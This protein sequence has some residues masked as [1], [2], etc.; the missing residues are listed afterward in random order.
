MNYCRAQYAF[1]CIYYPG[2][3]EGRE[4]FRSRAKRRGCGYRCLRRVAV[5]IYERIIRMGDA[6]DTVGRQW[7]GRRWDT[8][9][10]N[11]R[12]MFNADLNE[13]IAMFIRDGRYYRQGANYFRTS[14]RRRR[15]SNECRRVRAWWDKRYRSVGFA[16]FSYY[17]FRLRPFND[18]GRCS[19][20]TSIRCYFS[21]NLRQHVLV[22]STGDFYV[23][24]YECRISGHVGSRRYSEGRNYGAYVSKDVSLFQIRGRINRGC[25]RSG[26]CR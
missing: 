20:H 9:G 19:G 26:Y 12:G 15:I 10:W 1:M 22:R 5:G 4:R 7:T 23:A 8:K 25:G 21:G 6:T 17:V 18:R 24:N 2:V 11:Y 16:T 13:I 3:R 14:R